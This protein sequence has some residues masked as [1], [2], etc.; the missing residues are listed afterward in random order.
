MFN[1]GYKGVLSHRAQKRRVGVTLAVRPW[2]TLHRIP[3]KPLSHRTAYY[4]LISPFK[5]LESPEKQGK[6]AEKEICHIGAKRKASVKVDACA[7][8]RKTGLKPATP[9]LEG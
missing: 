6:F 3:I 7:L 1:G 4:P 2:T 8:E 5:H 9:S